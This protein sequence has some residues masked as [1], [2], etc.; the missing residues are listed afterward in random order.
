MPRRS[1]GP[2]LVSGMT[3]YGTLLDPVQF[4][5]GKTFHF[6][7]L[8]PR[9][10]IAVTIAMIDDVIGDVFGDTGKLGQ[11]FDSCGIQI[12]SCHTILRSEPGPHVC[13]RKRQ[14]D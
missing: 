2:G 13:R 8:F 5:A 11:L 10:E 1:E 3:E 6:Q 7:Q 14:K 4:F 12:D 9:G